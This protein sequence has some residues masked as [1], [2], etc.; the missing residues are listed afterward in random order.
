MDKEQIYI[1]LGSLLPGAPEPDAPAIMVAN[2]ILSAR[3]ALEL[4]EHQGI[5][6]SVGSSVS[7][8]RGFGWQIV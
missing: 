2:R 3:L 8:D 4:R 6:Y 5:A 1:L 7:F